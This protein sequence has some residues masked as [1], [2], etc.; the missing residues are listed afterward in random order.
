MEVTT[1]LHGNGVIGVL[2]EAKYKW[3]RRCLLTPSHAARLLRAGKKK[4]G[5]VRRIIVQP[6]EKRIYRDNQ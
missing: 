6:S 1:S 2:R 3:E 4:S 5:G